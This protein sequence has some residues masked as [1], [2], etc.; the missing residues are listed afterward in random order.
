ML[1]SLDV[2]NL[3]VLQS[4]Q[5]GG[6]TA[7]KS[8]YLGSV[9]KLNMLAAWNTALESIDLS[10]APELTNLSVYG[11]KLTALDLSS[12]PK[13]ESLSAGIA[14]LESLDLSANTAL[15]SLSLDNAGITSLDLSGLT[16]LTTF[17]AN[18][19]KM[20]KIDLSNSPKLTSFTVGAYG[21]GTSNDLKV[22]DMRKATKLSSVSLYSNVLEEVIVPKGTKTSSWN[23]TSYHMNPDTGAYD[24]VKV[25]EVEVEGGDDTP[26]SDDLTEGITEPFVKKIV[27][28]KFDKDGDG[29]ISAEEA[30][31]VT[32]LDFSECGLVDGDLAGLEV[33]P[34]KKLNLDGNQLTT[35]NIL[36]FPKLE[37][38]SLNYNKLTALSIGS[39]AS[40]LGQNLHLEAAHNKI[41]SF[42]CPSY[43]A[44][45]NYIDLSYN[46]LTG[47]SL[48]YATPLAYANLSHNELASFSVYGAYNI[49][50]INVSDNKLT[51]LSL[52]AVSGLVRV[53]A[54]NNALT[55][56]SF[57][58]G[59][60]KLESVNL[61]G[62]KLKSIDITPLIK[63]TAL[64]LID[65]TGNEDF[66]LVIVGAGNEI[67]STL[68]IRGVEGYNVLNA[69]N[70]TSY[71][72][73]QYNYISALTAGDKAEFGNITLNYTLATTG[74][75]I[76]DGG[77]ASITATAGK[78]VLALFA[79]AASGSPE[80]TI[81]RDSERA[82][83]TKDTDSS[84]YGASY[85]ATGTNP[86][87]P[88]LNESA[89]KDW[90]KF[91]VNGNG[92]RV[93][94]HF[95]LCGKSDGNTLDGEKI[96]FSVKGGT[97]VIFGINLSSYRVD[98]Q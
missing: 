84:P 60:T 38:I 18:A 3:R 40:D 61:A 13:L 78:K 5:T 1:E 93:L 50:E 86:L 20:E 16:E 72:T 70:P 42:T 77:S 82:I 33:F 28:S 83:L 21:S 88:S 80:I 4:V 92:D 7:L 57:G 52:N 19:T 90:T 10:E 45:V 43:S 25:T 46:K 85:A 68:E 89:G 59:Q 49:E 24:Y 55:S 76:E 94:Y 71:I 32:E 39:S 65:L 12:N 9:P 8:I 34:I 35:V 67:P 96:T 75:K 31:A 41:S 73:N 2:S 17:A 98:E 30:A 37:W 63:S 66:E 74:F 69:T 48:Q 81:T 23:W 53:D 29:A 91:V 14:T 97:A 22:V 58:S 62:N 54:S 11:S 36:A 15:K 95:S 87:S 26:S 47:F 27:L 64:K 51:S 6:V 44:K 56:Y 79:V